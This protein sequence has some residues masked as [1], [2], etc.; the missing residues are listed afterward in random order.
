MNED[1]RQVLDI[2][3]ELQEDGAVSK[4]IKQKVLGIKKDLTSCSGDEISL[5][6][7]KTLSEL[8]DISGDVNLPMFVRT[9]IWQLTSIL[10]KLS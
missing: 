6:V 7:N 3:D 2:L 10:E 9:Q 1:L 4:N 5:R 8:E